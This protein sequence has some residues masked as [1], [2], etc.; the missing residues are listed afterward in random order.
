MSTT[1]PFNELRDTGLLAL[2][3]TQVFHPRGY[4]LALVYENDD[5]EDLGECIG[6]ELIGDGGEAWHFP[7]DKETNDKLYSAN[8]ILKNNPERPINE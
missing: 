6:W 2:I 3:N 1:R 4:A 5:P 7:D 8:A